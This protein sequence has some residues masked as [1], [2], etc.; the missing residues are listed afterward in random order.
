MQPIPLPLPTITFSIKSVIGPRRR[1]GWEVEGDFGEWVPVDH[2][3]EV[4][5][6]WG[7]E[8]KK[9]IEENIKRN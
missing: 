3:T 5:C 1:R 8:S 6:C 7:G 2:S 9:Q 4:A